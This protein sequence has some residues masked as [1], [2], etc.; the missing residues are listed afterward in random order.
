MSMV[1]NSWCSSMIVIYILHEIYM[2]N[3]A[4]VQC[5]LISNTWLIFSI[6]QLCQPLRPI[7][8]LSTY[9]H[10]PS[11]ERSGGQH[12]HCCRF[13]QHGLAGS[14]GRA[15]SVRPILPRLSPFLPW[16]PF[17][18]KQTLKLRFDAELSLQS[19]RVDNVQAQI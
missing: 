2:N 8:G 13:V 6:K 15:D 10:C 16:V 19:T 17:N 3:A 9:R 4:S 18:S 14:Y 12:P 1:Y 7:C 5:R 11:T